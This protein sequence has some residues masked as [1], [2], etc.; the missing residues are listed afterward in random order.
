MII[1]FTGFDERDML[2]Y[3]RPLCLLTMEALFSLLVEAT[4]ASTSKYKYILILILREFSDK[5]ICIVYYI[6]SN[7][8]KTCSVFASDDM[9]PNLGAYKSANDLLFRYPLMHTP[10]LDSLADGSMLWKYPR[11][12]IHSQK[13]QIDGKIG[14]KRN[15]NF[16]L[17]VKL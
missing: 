15:I 8:I 7:F 5:M 13:W 3:Q 12:G 16:F 9:W 6:S 4:I 14:I 10:L 17:L 1:S 2:Q 11:S